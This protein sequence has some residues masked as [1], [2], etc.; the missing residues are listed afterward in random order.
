MYNQKHISKDRLRYVYKALF[1]CYVC[2]QPCEL[3]ISKSLMPVVSSDSLSVN[4]RSLKAL[5]LY[6]YFK[7]LSSVICVD[8]F[9]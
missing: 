8:I 3:R 6:N 5:K 7:G 4:L 2:C 9:N 1:L